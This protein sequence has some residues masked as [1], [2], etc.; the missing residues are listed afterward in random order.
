MSSGQNKT[1]V[2]ESNTRVGQLTL[3]EHWRNPVLVLMKDNNPII[4]GIFEIFLTSDSLNRR[5]ETIEDKTPYSYCQVLVIQVV[6]AIFHQTCK[7]L[8]IHGLTEEELYITKPDL[9]PIAQ[10]ADTIVTMMS[11][12]DERLPKVDALNRLEDREFYMLG[13]IP[14]TF[15]KEDDLFAFDAK[16]MDGQVYVKLFMTEHRARM[17][18]DR[19]F[20]VT[21]Y[22]LPELREAFRGRYGLIV[23]PKEDYA[24]GFAAEEL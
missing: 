15:N 23:E 3:V 13:Q 24:V 20:E 2:R 19:N 6:D 17:E 9:R 11:I 21:K 16:E 22:T 5:I 14:E 12:H 18:N 10:Q 7:G 8:S 1:A 4:N